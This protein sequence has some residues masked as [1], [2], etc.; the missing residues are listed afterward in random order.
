MK[1]KISTIP[2]EDMFG[3][4]YAYNLFWDK[5]F[6]EIWTFQLFSRNKSFYT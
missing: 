6:P 3:G 1:Y 2:I 5:I 4:F